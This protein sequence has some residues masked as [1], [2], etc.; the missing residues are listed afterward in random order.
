MPTWSEH[1]CPAWNAVNS[2]CRSI[3]SADWPTRSVRAS[4]ISSISIET[5][6]ERIVRL[7][8]FTGGEPSVVIFATCI[9]DRL[10]ATKALNVRIPSQRHA[11]GGVKGKH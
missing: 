7:R 6:A 2:T 1:L 11:E 10:L 8:R 5:L 4:Q 3:R 9:P